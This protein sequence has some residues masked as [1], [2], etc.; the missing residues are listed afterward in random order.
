MSNAPPKLA[1]RQAIGAQGKPAEGYKVKPKKGVVHAAA[2]PPTEE[3]VEVPWYDETSPCFSDLTT[4]KQKLL[5]EAHLIMHQLDHCRGDG[6]V[7][8]ET[9]ERHQQIMRRLD[10][11]KTRFRRVNIIRNTTRHVTPSHQHHEQVVSSLLGII[12]RRLACGQIEVSEV[13]QRELVEAKRHLEQLCVDLT[14]TPVEGAT[15]CAAK[16]INEAVPPE[17]TGR[18]RRTNPAENY[19]EGWEAGSAPDKPTGLP[20]LGKRQAPR[21]R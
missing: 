4:E 6:A 15:E 10:E 13:E 17:K 12:C 11:L 14:E 3:S 20:S 16:K 21:S 2:N 8:R 9:V 5:V 18:I 7:C 19:W 1:V